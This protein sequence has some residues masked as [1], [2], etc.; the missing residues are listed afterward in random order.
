MCKCG[1]TPKVL[2]LKLPELID[3]KGT[4]YDMGRR[5]SRCI[6]W[7]P[8]CG[9]EVRGPIKEKVTEAFRE[10]C[11]NFDTFQAL[12]AEGEFDGN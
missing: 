7:C 9:K 12:Q 1:T 2:V 6:M 11:K 8:N 3:E 5:F 4:L 10:A